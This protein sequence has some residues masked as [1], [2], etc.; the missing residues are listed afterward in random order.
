[1]M[2]GCICVTKRRFDSKGLFARDSLKRICQD[3]K[4][5]FAVQTTEND[6]EINSDL[7]SGNWYHDIILHD[8]KSP[9]RSSRSLS[10]YRE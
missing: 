1:M 5:H 4:S 9:Q 7:I 2:K 6:V 3:L 8:L 10:A